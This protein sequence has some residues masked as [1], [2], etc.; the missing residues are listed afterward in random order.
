MRTATIQLTVMFSLVLAAKIAGFGRCHILVSPAAY[1][2]LS[3]CEPRRIFIETRQT[4]CELE[5]FFTIDAESST[6]SLDGLTL[7]PFYPCLRRKSI[8]ALNETV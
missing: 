7:Q 5:P 8:A 6:I 2:F 4:P 1:G 3:K